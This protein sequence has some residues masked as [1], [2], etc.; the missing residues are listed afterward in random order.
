MKIKEIIEGKVKVNPYGDWSDVDKGLYVGGDLIVFDGGGAFGSSL[1]N[2]FLDD[3]VGK[4]VRITIEVLP[5][6]ESE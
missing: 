6:E 5:D 4:N 1:G 2:T 3:Y